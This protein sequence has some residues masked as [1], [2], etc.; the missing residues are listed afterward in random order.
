M[1]LTPVQNLGRSKRKSAGFGSAG[2]GKA[3]R[4]VSRYAIVNF[5]GASKKINNKIAKIVLM[6]V[7]I[8]SFLLT[9]GCGNSATDSDAGKNVAATAKPGT[10]MG[11]KYYPDQVH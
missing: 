2:L 3:G 6:G 4:V 9:V 5:G 10:K 11:H 7:A 8:T 1:R